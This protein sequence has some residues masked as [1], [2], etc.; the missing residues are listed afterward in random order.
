[1]GLSPIVLSILWILAIP[2]AG[3]CL[4]LLALTLLSARPK[5]P[6]HSTRTMRFDVVV[7]AHNEEAAIAGAV[8]STMAIDWPADRFR[9]VVVADNC[10]DDTA[11]VAAR[12]GAQVLI[13]QDAELRGK[14]YA[15]AYAFRD[16]RERRWADAVVIIDAD[17]RVSPNLL[18]AIAARMERGEQ[19]VQIHYGVSNVDASWRT[20]LMAIALAAF[21]R[22]RSR[23]RERLGVSCGIRGNGWGLTHALLEQVPFGS[24]SLAEDVEFGIELGMRGVRVAY[25]DEA[26]CEGE[27][28][29]AGT[30][31]R[32]QRRRWEQGRM[33]LLRSRTIPL[34]KQALIQRSLLCLDL[35]LDLLT[36]PLSY[37]ALCAA[38]LTATAWLSAPAGDRVDTWFALGVLCCAVVVL[39]ILRGWQLS[40]TGMRGL[41]DLLRTPFFLLWKLAV[42]FGAR[43]TTEWIRTKREDG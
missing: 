5:P 15:L 25:A 34:L 2:A 38:A 28:V 23:A 11:E 12:A 27:M 16:S 26:W 41:L 13:R 4:Y 21:H 22:V 9:V 17:S 36:L 7:P 20:R 32:S 39:Y 18:E 3:S 24:Y 33:A 35:A 43:R 8:V 1:M 40:N 42:M 31:A 37:V 14:G 30:N 10:T 19:A 6:L 29:T